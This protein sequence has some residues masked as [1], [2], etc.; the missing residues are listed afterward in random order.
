MGNTSYVVQ[1]LSQNI[2]SYIQ[3]PI[4]GSLPAY[5]QQIQL[6]P[7]NTFSTQAAPIVFRNYGQNLLQ[8]NSKSIIM[9]NVKQEV[10]FDKEDR[11]CVSSLSPEEINSKS[12][13][14]DSVKPPSSYNLLDGKNI[15]QYSNKENNSENQP[16][17]DT[18]CNNWKNKSIFSVGSLNE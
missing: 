10:Q 11:N 8:Q 12:E 7:M 13:V 18:S 5:Q 17:V 16:K 1:N 6:Q 3:T 4:L 14:S 15:I 2:P 9:T